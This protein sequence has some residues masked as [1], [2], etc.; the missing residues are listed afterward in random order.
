VS[1]H[2]LLITSAEQ[3]MRNPWLKKNPLMSL[4]LSTANSA[5]NSARAHA[6]ASAK[7]H[8]VTAM[9]SGT[10]QV[11]DFWTSALTTSRKRRKTR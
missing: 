8:T 9:S 10:K 11:V 5:M 1:P 6:A 4:W 2:F 7:R 3:L